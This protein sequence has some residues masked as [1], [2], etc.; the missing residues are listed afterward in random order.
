[1]TCTVFPC[2]FVIY[3]CCVL[4]PSLRNIVL[5]VCDFLTCKNNSKRVSCNAIVMQQH[6]RRKDLPKDV[7]VPI[8]TSEEHSFSGLLNSMKKSWWWQGGTEKPSL[9]ILLYHN[10]GC[11]LWE[12]NNSSYFQKEMRKCHFFLGC[13]CLFGFLFVCFLNSI[14]SL[15]WQDPCTCGDSCKEQDWRGLVV[16]ES[17]CAHLLC[18]TI[19]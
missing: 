5:K 16:C 4:H 18:P 1:M 9:R 6:E 12:Y 7:G 19:S 8:F 2:L 17:S 15:K 10:E 3:T 13:C 14:W 11:G